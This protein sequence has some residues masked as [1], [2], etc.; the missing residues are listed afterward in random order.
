VP[1]IEAEK[2]LIDAFAADVFDT[3]D[4]E[5]L[6]DLLRADL[7]EILGEQEPAS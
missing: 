5:V 2:I 7:S 3:L 1:R 6:R 4:S